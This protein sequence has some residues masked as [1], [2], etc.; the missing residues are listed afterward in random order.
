MI[1][2]F[3]LVPIF[4]FIIIIVFIFWIKYSWLKIEWTYWKSVSQINEIYAKNIEHCYNGE[5]LEEYPE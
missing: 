1:D 2:A 4:F 3:W 5:P